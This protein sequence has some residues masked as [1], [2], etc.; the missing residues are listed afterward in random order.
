MLSRSGLLPRPQATG[1]FALDGDLLKCFP[2]TALGLLQQVRSAID[3]VTEKGLP[4]QSVFDALRHQGQAIWQALPPEGQRR[5]LRHLCRWFEIHRFRM[6]PQI[7]E[8]VVRETATGR[9]HIRAGRIVSAA[10]DSQHILIDIATAPHRS[11]EQARAQWLIL[12]TGPDHE[13]AIGHEACLL[14]LERV[15]LITKD[16]HGLGIKC[17]RENRAV[18]RD[19]TPVEGLLIAGPLAR[20]T[21]GELT[22]VPEIVDQAEKIVERIRQMHFT[23]TRRMAMRIDAE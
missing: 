23:G 9:L 5:F 4:W 6:P 2:K 18:A 13:N 21:F 11:I 19:G 8:L 16:P 14:D 7:K 20:G 3:E 1:S 17:D 22:S 10:Y 12:A 15:G